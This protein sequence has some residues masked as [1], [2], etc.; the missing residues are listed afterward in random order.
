MRR[1]GDAERVVWLGFIEETKPDGDQLHVSGSTVESLI[2]DM[3][4]S[5][6]PPGVSRADDPDGFEYWWRQLNYIFNLPDPRLF[7]PLAAPLPG[8][9]RAVVDRF[10]ALTH[11]LAASGIVNAVFDVR[12]DWDKKSG[13]TTVVP[14]F[15]RLDVQA[16]F[17]ALLRQCENRNERAAYDRVHGI[18]W[19]AADVSDD[20]GHSKWQDL[21]KQ[22]SA[23]IR[24]L[25]RKSMN[26]LLRDRLVEREGWRVLEYEE[27]H[28]PEDLLRTFN[29]GDLLHWG[30]NRHAITSPSEDE[31]E[32]ALQRMDFLDAAVGLAHAIIGFGELAR[33]ATTPVDEILIP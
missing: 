33:A 31:A 29:Y 20:A 18:L 3:P 5:F 24:A 30:D 16:G 12:F 32:A 28:S 2:A 26:Q 6:P 10:I 21:L 9:D 11:Q 15:P 7:P 27:V 4:L 17:A 25:R 1:D 23:A 8:S 14:D 13:N 22:W 19:K